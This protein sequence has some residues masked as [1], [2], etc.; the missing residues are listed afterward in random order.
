MCLQTSYFPDDH[1]GEIIAQGLQDSLASWKLREDSLVC[2]TTDSGSNMIKALR[3]TEWPN[4]Q[5]FGQTSQCHHE[6]YERSTD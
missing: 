2:M 4:L 1:T 5:C 3:L 6:W